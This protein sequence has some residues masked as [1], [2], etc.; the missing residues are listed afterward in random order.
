[1]KNLKKLFLV[2]VL[3]LG[4]ISSCYKK[5]NNSTTCPEE[6]KCD[7]CP[8]IDTSSVNV[9]L[10]VTY[11]NGDEVS[12]ELNMLFDESE[13]Y[14]NYGKKKLK[15][16][17]SLKNAKVSF[18]STNDTVASVT[19]DGLITALK[20]NA[21]CQIVVSDGTNTRT[22]D[23]Y[24]RNLVDFFGITSGTTVTK[25]LDQ[26]IEEVTLPEGYQI[27]Q[28]T[29]Y[30]YLTRCKKLTIPEGYTTINSGD[31]YF[32]PSTSLVL[33]ELYLSTSV[34]N[35][36][37]KN[38]TPKL[39]KVV[40]AEGHPNLFTVNNQLL[41][42]VAANNTKISILKMYNGFNGKFSDELLNEITVSSGYEIN[43]FVYANYC[44]I[45]L[46]FL[47]VLEIRSNFELGDVSM[48]VGSSIETVYISKYFPIESINRYL[49][50]S[51]IN[52]KNLKEIK[53]IDEAED[54]SKNQSV[55]IS[56]GCLLSADGTTI[57][58][59]TTNGIIP[60]SVTKI[61]TF[62]FCGRK[63]T[64]P[65]LKIPS[66][67]VTIDQEAFANTNLQK[68][69]LPSSVSCTS[70]SK[71]Y[72]NLEDYSTTYNSGTYISRGEGGLV[73]NID[74]EAATLTGNK[75][76]TFALSNPDL[77]IYDGSETDRGSTTPQWRVQARKN[78]LFDYK[79]NITEEEFDTL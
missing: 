17:S 77:V 28:N 52:C 65:K 71:H 53:F 57:K 6:K 36:N 3:A 62:A 49:R 70:S 9:G 61:E 14:A 41:C 46:D 7:V 11:E 67:V 63:F 40:V 51:L 45:N 68:V 72:K 26:G 21:Y 1:M 64:N 25:I 43:T 55:S 20:A 32:A 18:K 66:N 56:D 33:E 54:T 16:I 39:K 35:F 60:E 75:L 13:V 42:A 79:Y 5:D 44:A 34:S 78:F 24:T 37:I 30:D 2:P 10:K 74:S 73:F 15:A 12:S 31:A 48:F 58:L 76:G 69:W 29:F 38:P 4:T 47:K 22:F 19:S 23:L 8:E 50:R 59:G 27:I